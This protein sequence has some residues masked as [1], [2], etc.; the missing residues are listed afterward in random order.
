M[1]ERVDNL[2]EQQHDESA[3]GKPVQLT[4]LI[5]FDRGDERTEYR[6]VVG[7]DSGCMGCL[8]VKGYSHF[9]HGLGGLI[10]NAAA[11]AGFAQLADH[12]YGREDEE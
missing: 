9:S 3:T 7:C 10:G 8:G 11:D 1:S 12:F 2:D 4:V 6:A 5:T